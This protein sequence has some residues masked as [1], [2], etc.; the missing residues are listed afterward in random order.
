MNWKKISKFSFY[1]FI[2]YIYNITKVG[3]I[4]F[5]ISIKLGLKLDNINIKKFK[6][7]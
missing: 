6:K 1:F 4:E 5:K 2:Y 3:K 7:E